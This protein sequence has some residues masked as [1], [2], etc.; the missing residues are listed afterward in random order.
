[1]EHND[2]AGPNESVIQWLEEEQRQNKANLFRISQQLE[3]LQNTIWSLAERV[4]AIE[5]SVGGVMGHVARVSKSEEDIRQ[6]RELVERVQTSLRD[7]VQTTEG[8]ERIRQTEL[9]RERQTRNELVQKI[10]AVAR[11]QEGIHDRIASQEELHRKTQQEL[12]H[13]ATELDPLR[14]ADERMASQIT[15]LQSTVKR[16]ESDVADMHTEQ[17][18]L[19]AQDDVLSGRLHNLAEQIRRLENTDDL[20]ELEERLTRELREQTELSRLERQRLERLV[21]DLEQGYDQSRVNIENL[22]QEFAQVSGR[23]QAFNDH[24]E[25]LRQQIWDLRTDLSETLGAVASTQEQHHRRTIAEL[26]LH[27]RELG[28]WRLAPPRT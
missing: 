3:Q 25:H 24:L 21:V 22:Q 4:N 19:R 10:D 27:L 5:G 23:V 12:F 11:V 9:E 1:M 18:S 20:A 13:L 2:A 16:T 7:H 8:D 6:T 15:G 14:V 17:N 26:E 28:Q